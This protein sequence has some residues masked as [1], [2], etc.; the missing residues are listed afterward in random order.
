MQL[1]PGASLRPQP[2]LWGMTPVGSG[3][4][5]GLLNVLVISIGL[6]V[7]TGA[8]EAAQVAMLVFIFGVI[9]GI[10]LG[11][12]LGL[13]AQAIRGWPSWLRM[14]LLSLPAVGLVAL[15]A[16][17]FGLMQYV[18]AAC[19]PT[20]VA[21]LILEKYTRFREDPAVPVA[22]ARVESSARAAR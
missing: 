14:A 16:S 13:I 18:V 3:L 19:I 5:L 9:P 17:P 10:T 7:S 20:L 21:T 8:S 11:G 12:L 22:V 2:A 1:D 15:L 6:G 4:M